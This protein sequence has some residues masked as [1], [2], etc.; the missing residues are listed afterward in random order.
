[1]VVCPSPMC[2]PH[3]SGVEAREGEEGKGPGTAVGSEIAADQSAKVEL[4]HILRTAAVEKS[5]S[6]IRAMELLRVRPSLFYIV[7][8][9]GMGTASCRSLFAP[10]YLCPHSHGAQSAR[11]AS[12]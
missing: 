10:S 4:S 11:T 7:Q 2:V 12:V 8:G 5:G 3:T 9:S 6:A 1:M